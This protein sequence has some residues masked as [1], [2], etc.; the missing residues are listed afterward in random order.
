MTWKRKAY[1]V[2]SLYDFTIFAHVN[3]LL[4]GKPKSKQS[5]QWNCMFFKPRQMST[6]LFIN[7]IN[8]TCTIQCRKI[9]ASK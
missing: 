5:Y 7:I 6:P 9:T 4:H 3:S 1:S 8:P 2:R